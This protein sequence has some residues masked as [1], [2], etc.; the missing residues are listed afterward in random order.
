MTEDVRDAAIFDLDG[1]LAD[2]RHRRRLGDDGRLDWKAFN[3]GIGDDPPDP[4]ILR[5]A[6]ALKA[7]GSAIV[8][9]SGRS[10]DFRRITE[11]W[12]ALHEVP[13]DALYM[14]EPQDGQKDHIVK[15]EM[16]KRIKADGYA[17][18]IVVD[19]RKS[20]VEMWRKAGLTCLQC[21][22]GDF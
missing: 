1:T 15:A 11:I 7:A 18:W 16:F 3:S 10:A 9:S 8:I 17:P 21:S 14:R 19:D 2:C 4:H 12:L 13:C 6:R 22:E 20:V 5:V